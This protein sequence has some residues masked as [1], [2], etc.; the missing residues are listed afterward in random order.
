MHTF[1]QKSL[2]LHGKSENNW[3]FAIGMT[4][5]HILSKQ[6]FLLLRPSW[7]PSWIP[8]PAIKYTNLCR[9]FQILQTIPNILVYDTSCK[10]KRFDSLKVLFHWLSLKMTL[11]EHKMTKILHILGYLPWKFLC[12]LRN[13]LHSLE[14]LQKFDYIIAGIE[15]GLIYFGEKK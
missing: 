3:F 10:K 13:H 12:F 8:Q 15:L 2:S 1:H 11:W 4:G 6:I 14:N 5:T 7:L 9:Q